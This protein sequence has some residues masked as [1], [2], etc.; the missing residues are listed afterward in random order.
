MIDV[1]PA[2]I[3][4]AARAIDVVPTEEM[5]QY[6]REGRELYPNTWACDDGGAW[7]RE[8][9]ERAIEMALHGTFTQRCV[10][11]G[12]ELKVTRKIPKRAVEIMLDHL[13]DDHMT[14]E[15]RAAYEAECSK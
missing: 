8:C 15:Q 6:W 9:A 4:R 7:L 2:V 5:V 13:W 3:R 12:C 11:R 14:D 10:H 1:T